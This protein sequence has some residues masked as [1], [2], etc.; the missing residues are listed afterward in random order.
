MAQMNEIVWIWMSFSMSSLR[1]RQI[2]IE[3]RHGH[4]IPEGDGARLPHLIQ[5]SCL[6]HSLACPKV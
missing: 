5:I 2:K 4:H 3:I 6:L 1:S